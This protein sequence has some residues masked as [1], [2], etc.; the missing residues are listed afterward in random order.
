MLILILI[1]CA[2]FGALTYAVSQN[3]RG[4]TGQMTSDQS[5]LAAEDIIS[6][7]NTLGNTVQKLKLQGCAD[8][9]FDFVTGSTWTLVN[10]SPTMT[11]NPS[12]PASGCSVFSAQDGKTQ[13]IIFPINYTTGVTPG[14]TSTALGHG[15]IYR[16]AVPGVGSSEQDVVYC[17]AR[18]STDVC[19][20]INDALGVTNP[21][22]SPPQIS[23][24]ATN[25]DGTFT[26]T[27]KTIIDLSGGYITGKT[28]FCDKDNTALWQVL[29]AR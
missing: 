4:S 11:A 16:V 3:M 19:L 13:S 5:K 26:G 6:Y 17:L 23:H 27:G 2:L 7:A 28:A 25:Y 12:A 22:G 20:K 14:P 15:K 21:G 8:N 1:A 10:G 9:Q 29:I 18:L 24:T